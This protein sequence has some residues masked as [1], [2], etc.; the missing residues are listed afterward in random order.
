VNYQP[1]CALPNAGGTISLPPDGCGYVS[2]TT[3][4]LMLNGLPPGTEVRVRSEH[5][6]FS[7]SLT[8]KSAFSPNSI[9]TFDS[10]LAMRVT[11]TGLL[12]GVSCD[13]KMRPVHVVV[14][15]EPTQTGQAVQD[16]ETDM[17][18]MTGTLSNDTTCNLFQNLTVL[19]GTDHGLPS[20]GHVH[21]EQRP[22]G[23]FD[24]QSSFNVMVTMSFEGK[25][26]SVLDGL[27]GSTTQVVAM[28]TNSAIPPPT[29][30]VLAPASNAALVGTGHTATASISGGGGGSLAGVPVSFT[31][32]SGP[33]AG[34]SGTCSAS[35]AC[36]T[37]ASGNV[38][39]TYTSNGRLGTD[40]ILACFVGSGGK[41]V[42]SAVASQSW[43]CSTPGAPC[44]DVNACTTGD[45]CAGGACAGTLNCDDADPCTS[46]S[47]QAMACV[48]EP[49]SPPDEI[50]ALGF[51]GSSSDDST[52]S[53]S[54]DPAA[55]SYQLLRGTL[56]NLPVGSA[57]GAFETCIATV[58]ATSA[59]DPTTPGEG[60]GFYYLV[61]GTGPCGTPADYGMW[62]SG[63]NPTTPRTSPACP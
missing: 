34:T 59:S 12:A 10:E 30:I 15:S 54:A 58:A 61:R 36:V 50:A 33:N 20:P 9:E 48:H 21:L 38:S 24:V 42:C 25:P 29:T 35:A 43:V 52:L 56:A 28:G 51:H 37:D 16:F 41:P 31:I 62:G 18:S 1:P 49:G 57:G 19:A 5:R 22:D 7:P 39:F 63:G 53:W 11:G 23:S 60:S 6:Y 40:E 26:G 55:T 32:T 8:L 27:S 46:D 44:D 45:Q 17:R 3:L 4:H 13:L 2:S 14:E 47:C